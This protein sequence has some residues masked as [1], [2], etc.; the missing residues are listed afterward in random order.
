MKGVF[1]SIIIALLIIGI[2][3]GGAYYVYY[4]YYKPNDKVVPAF[5]EGKLVLVIEGDQDTSAQEPK[6]VDGEI[7]LPFSI[8]KAYLDKNIYWDE[9]FS[10]LQIPK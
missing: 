9:A 10:T 3:A 5:D 1:K 8:V 6:I 2:L 4:I 7:L